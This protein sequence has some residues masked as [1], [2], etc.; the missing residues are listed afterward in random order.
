MSQPEPA[1]LAAAP[2][3]APLLVGAHSIHP[4]ISNQR[5]QAALMKRASEF[6]MEV[7]GTHHKGTEFN[8]YQRSISANPEPI[9]N[10]EI[11]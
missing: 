9:L 7:S 4:V 8:R 10:Y 1:A 11:E 6:E 2:G 3:S 5:S